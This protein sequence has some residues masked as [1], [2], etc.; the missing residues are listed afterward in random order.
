ML[1]M[2]P[3][4]QMRVF[5]VIVAVAVLAP[6]LYGGA[7]WANQTFDLWRHFGGSD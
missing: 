7:G 3:L 6:L 1:G 4:T 2:R 5:Y